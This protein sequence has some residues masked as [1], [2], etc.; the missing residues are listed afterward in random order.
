VQ[1][2]FEDM[3]T[4]LFDVPF[5]IL[6]L[7]TTG[8]S[9][10]SC[11]ITEIGAVRYRGGELEGRFQTLVNPGMAI[12]P[13]ITILTGITQ[14]MVIEAPP[15]A[16]ALPGFLEFIGDAV[17][18]GHNV[19]F[20]LSFIN[21]AAERHGYGRLPNRSVDTLA[22]SRRLIRKEVRN[23]KLATLA[24]H[25]RSPVKPTH[26]AL[27]DAEATAY[28]LFALLERAG[29]L[30]V[31]ALEDL[32]AL[33]TARGGPHYRK[34]ALADELPRRPGVYLFKDRTG[35]V[36]YVG[37]AKNLRTRVR[38]YFYG[39]GRRNTET[40]LAEMS[41]I[42]YRVCPTEI[43][44]S[45]TELRLIQ[46]HRPRHNRRSKPPKVSHW[47]TLTDERFP[48]LSITRTP[49]QTS[50]MCLGPFR[51]QK[52]ATT[53]REAIWDAVALRRCTG[54]PGL[55]SAPCAFSQLGVAA[56]PCDGTLSEADYRPIVQAVVA[57]ISVDP[58][59]LLLPL[60]EKVAELARAQRF[61]E[62]A[63]IRDR[64]VALAR[65]I[66]R[67]R[68]WQALEAAGRIFASGPD[69]I[70]C[71]DNGSLVTTWHDGNRPPLL[72]PH[73]APENTRHVAPSV[74]AAE[75]AQLLWA[76]LTSGNTRLVEIVG[77]LASPASPVP[78]LTIA[79]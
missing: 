67:R 37:K 64:Y 28:V 51:R 71:I 30:G 22:L 68:T 53:V 59:I 52:T 78:P 5:C 39:D 79:A 56:C 66:E 19:R 43:E 57:G 2:S 23:L 46:A 6:D 75:E 24:A 77:P 11:E 36:F 44:A 76:W 33:P 20:D 50:S 9:A 29:T 74:A 47:L 38:S 4:P 62:A 58:T 70:A 31:T 17:V 54:R 7:E 10:K 40:M 21:A 42:D 60:Q 34:I 18:V 48:R 1:R 61:E 49:K 73:V 27:D 8:G 69:G 25:F 41:T 63:W 72:P 55:R 16:E 12:P 35:S 13:T 14:A 26:R 15:I 3:G 65:A 32:L 45:V